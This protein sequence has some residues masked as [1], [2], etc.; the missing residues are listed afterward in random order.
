MGYIRFKDFGQ[1]DFWSD[2]IYRQM[3]SDLFLDAVSDNIDFSFADD[4]CEPF[5]SPLGQNAYAPSLMVRIRFV[6]AYFNLTDRELEYGLRYNLA[7]KKFVGIPA[8]YYSFDHSSRE[9]FDSRIPVVIHKAIFFHILAQIK[10]IGLIGSDEQWIIDATHSLSRA[11]HHTP[12]SLIRQGITQLTYA[13]RRAARNWTDVVDRELR[14]TD[15]TDERLH[16]RAAEEKK[17]Q[18][19]SR[20]VVTAFGLLARVDNLLARDILTPKYTAEVQ[21]KAIILRRILEE[22]TELESQ[23][24]LSDEVTYRQ[25]PKE[26]KPKNPLASAVDPDARHSAKSDNKHYMGHKTQNLITAES[27]F[28]VNIEGISATEND[29]EALWEIADEA[30]DNTELSPQKLLAD[31][32]YTTVANFQGAQERGLELVGNIKEPANPKGG[33]PLSSFHYD[34]VLQTLTCPAGVMSNEAYRN[35]S[36]NTTMFRFPV[37]ACHACPMKEKCTKSD[38]GRTVSIS[39]GY[40]LVLEVKEYIRTAEGK[41]ELKLRP[42]IERV[43]GVLKNRFG[44]NVTKSWGAKKYKIQGYWAGIAYNISRA[45][46]LLHERQQQSAVGCAA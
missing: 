14:L 29:G 9:D 17:L 45:V 34:P 42:M 25:K 11:T 1:L 28:I 39:D 37:T 6:Q 19:F 8:N 7:Y 30:R 18:Y 20:L 44:L 16:Y 22:N 43:N 41:A 13:L 36:T 2:Q 38:K 15:I 4:I 32:Q 31:G 10:D 26:N 5:Y 46:K 27:Q 24:P 12:A 33:Y 3:P 35:E 21:E 23:D 40:P